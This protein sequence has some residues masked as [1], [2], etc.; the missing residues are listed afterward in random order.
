MTDPC[1]IF[2]LD[3]RVAIV[4]GASSGL[5]ERFARLLAAAGANVVATAR[6]ADR[7]ADLAA[8]VEGVHAIPCDVTDAESRA[9]LLA[10]TVA[11]FGRVDVLVNNAGLAG[12]VP[13][14]SE[15]VEHFEAL[16]DV[17]LT[18][19]FALSQLAARQMIEQGAG[20]IVNIA[21]A[22][23]LVAATPIKQAA[24][25]ASKGGV[26]N[27]TRQLGTEWAR[28]GIRVNAIAP[29]FFASEMTTDLWDD[30]R[31]LEWIRRTDPMG[32]TGEAHELDGALLLLAGE[33][34]SYITGQTI[35]VD[36]GWTAI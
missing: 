3:G 31:S 32:R 12:P 26:V 6:R 8:E 21:S 22:H 11:R 16:V 27:L 10:E 34:G 15:T 30:E 18:A 23:G 17:N 7:L 24:Y 20:A 1:A 19:L 35:A 5:G 9:A 33:A 25:A 14:E 4:T 2:R 13:S 36:G 29:G 28:K